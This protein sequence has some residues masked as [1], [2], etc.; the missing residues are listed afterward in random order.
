MHE[1]K[2]EGDTVKE[3]NNKNNNTETIV[4]ETKTKENPMA[5]AAKR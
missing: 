3:N 4:F 2:K 5:M 1:A